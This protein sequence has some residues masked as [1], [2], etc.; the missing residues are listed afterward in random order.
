MATYAIGDIQGC[1]EPFMRLLD[2]I[3]FHPER[4]TL[5]VTGDLVNR[6][7]DSLQVLRYLNQLGTRHQIVLGNHD[8]HL[9]AVSVGAHPPHKS[10]TLTE[11]LHAPDRDNLLDWLRHRPMLV[12]HETMPFVMTHAGIAPFWT[13]AKAKELAE[14][15][16]FVLRGTHWRGFFSE[17][18]GN[19][20][21]LW[22]DSLSGAERLRCIV[23]YMT[24]MRF[25]DADG[26]LDLTNKGTVQSA[27]PSYMP[28]FS[29]KPRMSDGV[30]LVFGH[31]AALDGKTDEPNMYALDTG[32]VWGNR[33]SAM[34]LE[35]GKRF[36][37]SCLRCVP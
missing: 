30:S 3:Q 9:L 16:E 21:D 13:I 4:D 17:M 15:V 25:C 31:W 6:G 11:I 26:R 14:E 5:W 29:V 2:I 22:Q 28:W 35:D 24:R 32:C 19:Q 27:D 10:D 12:Q 7:P 1:Y 34:R 20:P 23:N 33:L 8:L 37:T 36:G 18:Y